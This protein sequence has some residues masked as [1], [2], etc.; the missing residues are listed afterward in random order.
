MGIEFVLGVITLLCLKGNN[1]M[2]NELY[3]NAVTGCRIKA[4][5]NRKITVFLQADVHTCTGDVHTYIPV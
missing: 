2:L 3:S 5:E 4:V 1:Q